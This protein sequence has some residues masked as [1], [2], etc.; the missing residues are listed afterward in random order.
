MAANDHISQ[1]RPSLR[2]ADEK[3]LDFYVPY[4]DNKTLVQQ[5]GKKP[6]ATPIHLKIGF[7][8]A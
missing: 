8:G 2:V 1:Y 6:N 5:H 3:L 7:H 4:G